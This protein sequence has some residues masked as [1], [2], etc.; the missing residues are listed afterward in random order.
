MGISGEVVKSLIIVILLLFIV[1]SYFVGRKRE[2]SILLKRLSILNNTLNDMFLHSAYSDVM[3]NDILLAAEKSGIIGEKLNSKFILSD[4]RRSLT[5][6]E[7]YVKIIS[8]YKEDKDC[9]VKKLILKFGV[10]L[11]FDFTKVNN[12]YALNSEQLKLILVARRE[13][14]GCMVDVCRKEEFYTLL[15]YYEVRSLSA[16]IKVLG[17][18]RII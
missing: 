18:F 2:K 14:V 7:H 9:D 8:G 15:K 13:H 12:H 10:N 3:M 6:L 5:C 16:K 17:I 11:Y 4:P 1:I